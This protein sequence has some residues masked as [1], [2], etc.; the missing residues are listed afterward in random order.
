MS[1]WRGA[2]LKVVPLASGGDSG[3]PVERGDSGDL[4]LG[5]LRR[6][7]LD[8]SE[9]SLYIHVCIQHYNVSRDIHV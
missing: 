6:P 1:P 5:G 2:G 7:N 8:S 4:L 3:L 9:N